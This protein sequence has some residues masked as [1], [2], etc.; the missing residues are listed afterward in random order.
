MVSC[1]KCATQLM[2][3][4]QF[5]RICGTA[6]SA[7][8][9]VESTTLVD[10][11]S[12]RLFIGKNYE[13]FQKK[14]KLNNSK[15][16]W[17]WSAFFGGVSWMAYRKMYLYSW[18]FIGVATFV[19]IIQSV[20]NLSEST[21]HSIDIAFWMTPALSGNLWYK[22]HVK[23]MINEINAINAPNQRNTELVV[24]GRTSIGAAILFTFIYCICIFLVMFFIESNPNILNKFK[25]NLSNNSQ[26]TESVHSNNQESGL[27]D[28]TP[29]V[30]LIDI[31]GISVGMTKKELIEKFP[32]WNN[33][34]IA[35]I[36]SIEGK[37]VEVA[38]H[39]GKL[40]KFK[41]FFTSDG[42]NDV[43][44]VVSVKYPEIKCKESQIQNIY[45]NNFD[46]TKCTIIGSNADLELTRFDDDITRSV[47]VITS[48]RYLD[49]QIKK[50]RL[51]G[52]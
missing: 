20:F 35:N 6:A 49:E 25:N 34:T 5:C 43:L 36:G 2:E 46:Q 40:D 17:S 9:K 38:F 3:K 8:S 7:K 21:S 26:Q 28:K 45:G 37:P 16:S 22:H 15:I 33:F 48:R 13:Y 24:R 52:V 47:L 18:I 42:F 30:L 39:D 10:D 1:T 31:R 14:W 27:D 44:D 19:T 12:L 50:R 29:P 41:F 51:D 32:S 23:K 11:D 4:D